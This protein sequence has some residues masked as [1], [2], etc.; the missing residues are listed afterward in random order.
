MS[1]T[2]VVDLSQ[3][4]ALQR[5]ELVPQPSSIARPMLPDQ[6]PL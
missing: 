6:L 1:L 3:R 2:M 5:R 4:K